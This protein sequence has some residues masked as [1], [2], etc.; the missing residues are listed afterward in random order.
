MAKK[1]R[2]IPLLSDTTAKALIKDE[3]YRWFYEEV[4]KYKTGI[5]LKEY[6]LIDT[7]LNTGNK[8]KD[9]RTALIFEK[10]KNL[11]NLEFNKFVYKYTLTKNR[12]YALRL[13]GYGY[14]S[15]EDYEEKYVIQINLN[16]KIVNEGRKEDSIINYKLQDEKYKKELKNIKIIEI[17]LLNY[18][19]I[20][21]NK[22]NKYDTYLSMLTA[23]SFKEL[24]KIVGDLEEGRKIMEK[25]KE[26]GLD[27]KYGALYDAEIVHKKEINSARNEGYSDGK[28]EGKKDGITFVA[29]TMLK[30]GESIS[31][32]KDYTGLKEKD[33]LKLI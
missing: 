29:K 15:G 28:K 22:T 23:T 32:I 10:G 7:E 4:I 18:K 12:Y 2:F 24:E 33:I 19:G 11:V 20:V 16:N 8:V 14:L 17:Y 9:Y 13:A 21:Y 5:D 30:S 6:K 31:K 1:P 25:L 26:L 27:D 3:N